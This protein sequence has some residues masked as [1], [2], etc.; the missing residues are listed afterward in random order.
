MSADN[1]Y[2]PYKALRHLDVIEAVREHRPVRPVHVQLI[3][4]DLCNQGCHFCSYRDPAYSSSQRFYQIDPS[5][6]G[7]RR[8]PAHPEHNYNPNRMIPTEKALEI[9]DDCAEMGVHAI[10]FT[11]GGEPTVHPDFGTIADRC[12]TAGMRYAV[13]TNGVNVAKKGYARVLAESSWAR[14]SLDAGT[15]ETYGKMRSVPPSQFEIALQAIRDTRGAI[16]DLETDCHLGVGFVVNPENWREVVT[17]TQIAR[18]SGAHNVRISAQFSAQDDALFAGF[19]SD[20]AALCR[21]AETLATAD[22]AVFNRFSARVEDLRQKRPDY[23][24]CGYQHFTTYVGADLNVYRCCVLAYND[25]GIVGS[26]RD[27]RFVDLWLDEERAAQF[28]EFD[29][30]GC[31]RCQFRRINQMLDYALRG[32]EPM[33]A[34]FV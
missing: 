19:H 12:V 7:L 15:A 4:S 33:H 10:Q 28:A 1:A 5:G 6:R 30:R 3:L 29:A 23:A 34:E 25:R 26:L 20:A 27:R 31:E 18:D 8:D 11:G 21:E 17:A 16:Y 2:S 24:I 13:V 32:D 22:F 9:L 14:I